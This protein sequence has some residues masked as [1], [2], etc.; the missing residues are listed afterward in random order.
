MSSER[1]IQGGVKKLIKTAGGF[2]PG[3]PRRTI[4]RLPHTPTA[5]HL[6]I[7]SCDVQQSALKI[8]YKHDSQ[9]I[10]KKVLNKLLPILS[11]GEHQITEIAIS[12]TDIFYIC[13]DEDCME[14]RSQK[15][16]LM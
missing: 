3:F 4:R 15:L 7:F 13:Q 5:F 1:R 12:G 2:E 11:P 8:T 16:L 9:I 10:M 6:V 14:Y